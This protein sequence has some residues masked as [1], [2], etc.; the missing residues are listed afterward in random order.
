MSFVALTLEVLR[1]PGGVSF[2]WGILKNCCETIPVTLAP[3][4]RSVLSQRQREGKVTKYS[5]ERLA[6]LFLVPG[7]WC[8]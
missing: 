5:G 1:V 4:G 6:E 3:V 8:P 2:K 7:S